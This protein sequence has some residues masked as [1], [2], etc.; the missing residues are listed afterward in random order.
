MEVSEELMVYYGI[1]LVASLKSTW[2]RHVKKKINEK[3]AAE[4]KEECSKKTKSRTVKDDEFKKKEYIGKCSI[5]DTKKII[6]AR[7]HM[8]KIPGN[9]KQLGIEKCPLLR[10]PFGPK[11]QRERSEITYV[12]IFIVTCFTI[13]ELQK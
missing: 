7:L 4:I 6:K 11:G 13:R 2:K 3:T 5:T 12:S 8:S 1:T 10:S 9:L